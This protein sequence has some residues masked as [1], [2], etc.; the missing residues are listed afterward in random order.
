MLPSNDHVVNRA[1][2]GE[3]RLMV[4]ERALAECL[5]HFLGELFYTNAGVIIGY[6][7]GRQDQNIDDIVASSAELS[8]RP[9]LLHYT[10]HANIVEEWGAPPVVTLEMELQHIDLTAYFRIEFDGKGIGITI[11][12]IVFNEPVASIEDSF[13]RFQ[14]ALDECRLPA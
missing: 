7:H 9:G 1:T 3:Q 5:R 10:H 11:E 13:L 8:L 14:H 6:I 2:V 4:Y 12:G